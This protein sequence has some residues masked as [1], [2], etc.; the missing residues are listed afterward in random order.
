MKITVTVRMFIE[1]ALQF[2]KPEC[3]KC[4]VPLEQV[5]VGEEDT[6][7]LNYIAC[8]SCETEYNINI[9]FVPNETIPGG[10]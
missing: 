10:R 8:P 9:W 4:N 1:A 3:P 6:P 7:V 2:T 5:W